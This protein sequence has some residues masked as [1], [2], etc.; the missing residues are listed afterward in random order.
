MHTNIS[1]GE[2]C[3]VDIKNKKMLM[4]NAVSSRDRRARKLA[5]MGLEAALDAADPKEVLKSR[6]VRNEN[7]LRIDGQSFDL[8]KFKKVLVVGG[9]KASVSMGEALEEILGDHITDGVLIIP[10]N[11]SEY[12]FE[13]IRLHKASHPVPDEAGVSAVKQILDMVSQGGENALI[14]CLIS[15][16]GSSLMPL[17]RG[18]I[19]LQEKIIVSRAL[20]NSGAAINEINTVR[21]HLSDFKG[22]LFAKK[23]YPSTIINLIF[24]DVL[25][26]PLDVIASGPSVPDS[27]TFQD[28]IEVLER[29]NLWDDT[30]ESI[31]TVLL[32]GK[33][34][35]IAETPKKDDE[36]FKKVHN[37]VVGNN[38][39]ASFA[40]YN[41]LQRSGLNTLLLTSC[42]E[43]EARHIGTMLSTIAREI[44]ETGKPVP[45]PAG[46]VIGGETTVTVLGKGVGGRNQEITL[47]AALKIQGL[48]GVVVGSFSTDGIDGPTDAAGALADGR[49]V[50]RSKK[51]DLNATKALLNNDSYTFFSKL[52]DLIFTGSTGT[53]LND[54]SIIIAI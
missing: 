6:V 36:A 19:S 5:L 47:G 21:K 31:K 12:K 45:R 3:M 35:V 8:K 48:D 18:N 30:P 42:V 51:L 7:L 20:L 25:G 10:Y 4:N 37:F 26:D 1:K 54:V 11:D 33:K 32:D 9:G 14:I 46:I 44:K 41:K 52:G 39:L 49:T 43:G 23:A 34:G 13:R 50:L 27:S 28:A 40:V 16:G 53:N 15:G 22:G 29:H 2:I 24:S 38:R 17:P